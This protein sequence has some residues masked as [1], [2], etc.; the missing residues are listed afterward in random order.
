MPPCMWGVIARIAAAAVVV[1]AVQHHVTQIYDAWRE[2]QAESDGPT[3]FF[4]KNDV[5]GGSGVGLGDGADGEW[6]DKSGEKG[7]ARGVNGESSGSSGKGRGF[8]TVSVPVASTT[9]RGENTDG[10]SSTFAA[11]TLRNRVGVVDP[12]FVH[13][14]LRTASCVAR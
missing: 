1:A 6:N 5:E 2:E 9:A 4:P 12:R 13:A 10:W 14:A 7:G 11:R 8:C 3:K